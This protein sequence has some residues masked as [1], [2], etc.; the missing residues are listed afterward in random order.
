MICWKYHYIW[1]WCENIIMSTN[2]NVHLDLVAL[3]G[4]RIYRITA[5]IEGWS[6]EGP[7]LIL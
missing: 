5:E 7:T 4:I 3:N 2:A 1:K 6:P